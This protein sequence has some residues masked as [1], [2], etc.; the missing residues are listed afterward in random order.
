VEEVPGLSAEQDYLRQELFPTIQAI[1]RAVEQRCLVPV[2]LPFG[3]GSRTERI[4]RAEEW[5]NAEREKAIPQLSNKHKKNHK[6]GYFTYV[7]YTRVGLTGRR[8]VESLPG[9]GL[10]PLV[11]GV[12]GVARATGFSGQGILFWILIDRLPTLPVA[13]IESVP[14]QALLATGELVKTRSTVIRLFA[15][16][17]TASRWL[18][19]RKQLRESI[20]V[21]RTNP[22]T[23]G[24]LLLAKTVRELGGP[25]T[26][27]G[28]GVTFWKRARD[29]LFEHGRKYE[30]WKGVRQAYERYTKKLERTL[31]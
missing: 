19:I 22:I 17:I 24:D 7:P 28:E 15:H 8:Y 12:L 25:P 16:D 29:V 5:L 31:S 11:E 20:G 4:D 6:P 10:N 1:R 14:R 9:S 30:S 26:A 3:V 21:R 23:E 18:K 27:W 13:T 2:V